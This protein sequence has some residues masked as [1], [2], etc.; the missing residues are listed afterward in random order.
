[1]N[2][3]RAQLGQIPIL[4]AAAVFFILGIVTAGLSTIPFFVWFAFCLGAGALTFWGM[5]KNVF[6]SFVFLLL[7]FGLG[8]LHYRNYLFL[9]P[10]H[11]ASLNLQKVSRLQ[12]RGTIENDPAYGFRKV[13]FIF[14]A[15]KI[16]VREQAYTV[17][18]LVGVNVYK[19]E[20]FSYGDELI[21]EGKLHRPFS[22]GREK[23]SYQEYLKAQG[24]AYLFNVN[25]EGRIIF[26]ER[27]KGNPFKAFAFKAK[28]KCKSIFEAYLWPENSRVLSGIILGDRQNF[29]QNLRQAFVRTG[30]SHII[31]ISGFNVGIVAFITLIL[32]KALGIKRKA[33]YGITLPLL[34]VHMYAVGAGASVVRATF[35]AVVVLLAYLIGKEPH[36]INSLSMAA[37]IIL[38]YNPLQIYDVGFQLSFVSVLG[39][40][41]L[42]SRIEG[43]L[44]RRRASVAG[45]PNR[46]MRYKNCMLRFVLNAFSVSFA[47]WL[48]TFSFI[49]YY[50]RIFSPITIVANVV[51][52]PFTSLI[53]V[54]GFT[55]GLSALVFP[56]VSPAIAATAN[57][58]LSVL[59]KITYWLSSAPFAYFYLPQ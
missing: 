12:M 49:A 58:A 52:V 27:A 26:L 25:Q 57:Y 9:P 38:G 14:R 20:K 59:F 47:A 56:A 35:M 32:L 48:T 3:I 44:S 4:T 46:I 33:R 36:I 16:A 19:G 22:F 10:T 53:I 39:I 7:C 54:L 40:V 18:G 17:Q 1:M 8:G 41:L 5:R 43:A 45:Q 21:L 11:I 6:F 29:P 30:T 37:L 23:F 31:A 34:I 51:I 13:S 42:S 28:H 15:K 50:F 24:I 55:L 2:K